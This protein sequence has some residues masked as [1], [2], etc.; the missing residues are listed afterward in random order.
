MAD[1]AR[2]PL[3]AGWPR[4]ASAGA[5]AVAAG[6]VLAEV[7][8]FGF[9]WAGGSPAPAGAVARAGTVLFLTFNHVEV[10]FDA[11]VRSFGAVR[12]GP[13]QVA[14]L[15]TPMLGTATIVGALFMAGRR[16]AAR[17]PGEA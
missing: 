7:A 6:L 4:A 5:M 13:V 17:N 11:A 14:L 10:V 1:Q 8:A 12:G 2:P 3:L 16:L 15:A 9:A